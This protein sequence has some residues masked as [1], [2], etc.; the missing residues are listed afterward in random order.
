M[1]L[2]SRLLASPFL[3]ADF[4]TESQYTSNDVTR[5]EKQNTKN[6]K[7]FIEQTTLEAYI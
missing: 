2:Y 1:F 7:Q 6:W 4:N 3:L 5:E